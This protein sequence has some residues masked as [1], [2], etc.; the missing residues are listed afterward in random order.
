MERKKETVGEKFK[1]LNM[2][3]RISIEI[4]HTAGFKDSFIGAFV[5]KTVQ[6]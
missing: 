4:L 2:E 1:H 5:G 3:D 6:A